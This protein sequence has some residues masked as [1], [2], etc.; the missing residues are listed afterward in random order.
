MCFDLFIDIESTHKFSHIFS[1]F[2]DFYCSEKSGPVKVEVPVD[3]FILCYLNLYCMI[4]FCD[5][6]IKTVSIHTFDVLTYCKYEIRKFMCVQFKTYELLYTT[7]QTDDTIVQSFSGLLKPPR[8]C[9]CLRPHSRTS[10]RQA[11]P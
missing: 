11:T 5:E 4:F 10:T 7:R 2:Y 6:H 3:S 1:D 8:W 9:T